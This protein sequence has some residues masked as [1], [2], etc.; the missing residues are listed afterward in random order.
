MSNSFRFFIT[1]MSLFFILTLF[2]SSCKI[3]P[4][5]K[6]SGLECEYLTNPEGVDVQRPRFSWKIVS[7]Q[8]GISQKAYRIITGRQLSD[9]ENLTGKDWDQ[10]KILSGATNNIEYDG[11]PLQSNEN[12][13]WRVCVWTSNGDQFWSQPA[14]FHTGLIKRSD[15]KAKWITTEEEIIHASPLLRKSFKIGKEIKSAYA[16]VT[17]GGIYEFYLN[18]KK[19]GD[20][21]L[22]PVI[23]NYRKTVLYTTYDVTRMLK[24]GTNVAGAML[25]NGAYNGK[26][27]VDRYSW[28]GEN[29]SLGNPCFL[30]QINI[31]YTDGSQSVIHTDES[32]KYTDGPVTFN[33]FY[34]GE[35]YDA[36]K[37]IKNW[38]SDDFDDGDWKNALPA[39]EPGG[40]LKSLMMPPVKI[41]S[42]IQPVVQTNPSPGVY[43]FDLGQNIAGWWRIRVK[44]HPAQTVRVRGAET[45][46][47]SLF[48]KPIEKGD[49]LSTKFRYHAQ[50]WTDY[51]LRG[52]GKEVYEPRFFYSGFRYIE[53]ATNDKKP[54]DA[55]QVEGRVVRTAL[56][57]A[58]TFISSDSLLNKINRAGVWAI[59][60]NT[61]SYPT[62]CPHREK[63]A[64]NGD[65]QVI[66]ETSMHDF[67]MTAFYTKWLNDMRDSQE[68]NGRIPNT[69]PTLVGGMGGGVAW[70]SAYILIPWWMQHYYHDDRILKEHYPTMK[71]YIQYLKDLGTK[72]EHPEE[73]Y[74]INF[75]DQYWYSLGEWCA[76]GQ[77]DGPNH[78]VVNTFYYFYNTLL[79]SKI[80][81]FLGK[82]DDSQYFKNLSDTIKTAFNKKFF[83]PETALYGTEETYQTYQLLALVGDMVPEGYQEKVLNTIVDDIKN[84]GDHLN[85]GIIGTKYIWPVLVE[86]NY[87]D[88]AYEVATKTTYPGYGF[89]LKNNATTLLEEWT[90]KGSH[91]H[92]MF[93]SVIE[94][95]YKYLAGIQSPME[96][97][98]SIGYRHIHLQPYV[99][100]KLLFVNASVETIAGKINAAWKKE[101]DTFQY[102]TSIPANTSATVVL[103]VFNYKN[104]LISESGLT[105]WDSGNFVSGVP[106]VIN[107]KKEPGHIIISIE[108]GKYNFMISE[109]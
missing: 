74:I 12:Y 82:E 71:R 103:P 7:Q 26:K 102:N 88:L 58:G 55:L 19:I 83:N 98:T 4:E 89:W 63:G 53:V 85:T 96:G 78:A 10:G 31:T 3:S 22:D 72:D 37:E 67:N 23:T 6:V 38:M 100:E 20:H 105:I 108:S 59:K 49:V 24:S 44:G 27:V 87:G 28:G 97:N 57:K 15:W 80:A 73:P 40:I 56:E 42:T 48:S 9:L 45:L 99:P 62:D 77:S 107:V 86:G 104:I 5:L 50:V 84:R 109:K 46:N 54:L 61:I 68:D 29:K 76:P 81:K 41:T 43:L 14:R 69:S 2:V 32:W 33:N 64:Y 92:Q 30:A 39:R 16:F 101:N 106:G 90:G 91:N 8:R 21:V 51:T 25:G 60:G 52:E 66:A 1:G 75:F 94:Y 35:D 93:G 13:Y 79:M 34:G 65:G 47:D 36:R 11:V 17:A 95:F 18:G 70:G